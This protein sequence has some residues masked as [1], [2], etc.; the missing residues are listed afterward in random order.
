MLSV[1]VDALDESW[2]EGS[3]WE[4]APDGHTGREPTKGAG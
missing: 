3:F 2:L 4:C 1:E